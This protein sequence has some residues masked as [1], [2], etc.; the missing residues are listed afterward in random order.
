[1]RRRE[2]TKNYSVKE[3]G[4]KANNLFVTS[5]NLRRKEKTNEMFDKILSAKFITSQG[6]I[7]SVYYWLIR[8]DFSDSMQINSKHLPTGKC[9]FYLKEQQK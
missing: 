8:E 3:D 1:M 2:N 5:S 6:K 9:F 4:T 7:M